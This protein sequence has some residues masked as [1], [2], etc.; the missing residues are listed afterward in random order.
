[1]KTKNLYMIIAVIAV[2]AIS[3][4]LFHIMGDMATHQTNSSIA[5]GTTLSG[6]FLAARVLNFWQ[7]ILRFIGIAITI[8]IVLFIVCGIGVCFGL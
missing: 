6:F 3:I 5:G 8:L 1:M 2:L 4:T 7:K